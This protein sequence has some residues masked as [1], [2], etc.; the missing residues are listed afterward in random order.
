M[1]TD[2]IWVIITWCSCVGILALV[3]F[4]EPLSYHPMTFEE[5]VEWLVDVSDMTK[6]EAEDYLND[7][8][9]WKEPSK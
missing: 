5:E 4:S 9:N 6:Q 1:D 8:I 7:L 2:T 3:L